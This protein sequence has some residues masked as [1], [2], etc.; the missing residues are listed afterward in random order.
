M[1]RL[2]AEDLPALLLTG[3]SAVTV[4]TGA[5]LLRGQ[6]PILMLTLGVGVAG[7]TFVLDRLLVERLNAI[8]PR[9]SLA[10]L[11]VCWAPLFL[12]A[13]AL[14]TLATFSWIAPELSRRDLEQSRRSH[15]S[16]EAEKGATYLGLVKTS[17][18]RQSDKT[19]AAIDAERQHAAAARRE[20]R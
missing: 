10:S 1:N 13:A 7:A 4:T 5:R 20:G 6:N 19:Q 9:Q 18:R 3:V 2:T 11:V 8:R 17:L 12:F 15:W 16:S 14:A